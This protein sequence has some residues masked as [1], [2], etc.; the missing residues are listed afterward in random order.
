MEA[1]PPRRSAA[2]AWKAFLDV[3]VA[4]TEDPGAGLSASPD[5]QGGPRAETGRRTV[6]AWKLRG[7]RGAK[8][9]T[10]RARR[11]ASPGCPASSPT[12]GDP[13]RRCHSHAPRVL[14]SSGHSSYSSRTLQVWGLRLKLSPFLLFPSAHSERVLLRSGTK[15]ESGGHGRRPGHTGWA[16]GFS[17]RCPTLIGPWH[18]LTDP[19][20]EHCEPYARLKGMMLL[21]KLGVRG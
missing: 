16:V 14:V 9:K 15:A 8:T 10:L 12:L 20:K 2:A 4:Q 6:R 13:S 7:T 18:P 19:S 3:P 11:G 21:E 5:P 1:P 17:T